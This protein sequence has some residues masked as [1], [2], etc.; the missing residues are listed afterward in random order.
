MACRRNEQGVWKGE[1]WA[2]RDFEPFEILLAPHTS[3]LKDTHVT[4]HANAVVTLPRHGRGAHPDGG[5]LALDGRCRNLLASEGSLDE[6]SHTG[7]LF[8]LVTRSCNPKEASMEQEV[9]NFEATIKCS[10]YSPPALKKR[11]T[12][13]VEWAPQEM[14]AIPF[15][16]NRKAIAAKTKLAMFQPLKK[17]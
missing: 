1:V 3:Q 13:P 6:H 15:L 8:W 14:P 2:K 16:F 10:F 12:S 9:A 17:K 7:S 11:K 4:G 5:S